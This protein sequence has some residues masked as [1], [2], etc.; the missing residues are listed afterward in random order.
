MLEKNPDLDLMAVSDDCELVRQLYS[1]DPNPNAKVS[2]HGE[3]VGSVECVMNNLETRLTFNCI[4][5][6]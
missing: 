1:E 4:T 3:L 2:R 6:F 5:R